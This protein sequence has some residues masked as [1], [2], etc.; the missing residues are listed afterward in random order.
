MCIDL[1]QRKGGGSSKIDPLLMRRQVEWDMGG[2]ALSVF[3]I[4]M[5]PVCPQTSSWAIPA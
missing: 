1:L 2:G 3:P 4:K 5:C